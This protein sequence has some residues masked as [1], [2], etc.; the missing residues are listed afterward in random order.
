M[1]VR[2]ATITIDDEMLHQVSAILGTHGI[3]ATIHEA[4]RRVMINEARK[5]MIRRL[6]TM[7]GLDLDNEEIMAG[8]WAD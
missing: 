2:K 7:E 1:T 3:S 5:R 6:R 8:A 4:L